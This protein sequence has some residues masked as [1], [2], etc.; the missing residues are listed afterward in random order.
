VD[1]WIGFYGSSARARGRWSNGDG[2]LQPWL[3]RACGWRNEAEAKCLEWRCPSG[4][5][6]LI[7]PQWENT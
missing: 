7:F 6:I 5:T 1:G 2:E 3:L 4:E